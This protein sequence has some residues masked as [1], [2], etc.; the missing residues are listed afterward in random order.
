[1]DRRVP[2]SNIRWSFGSLAEAGKGTIAG[3]RGMDTTTAGLME[4]T[5]RDSVGFTEI[6]EPVWV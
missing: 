3:A 2:Q 1:M 4:S 6:R 5:D